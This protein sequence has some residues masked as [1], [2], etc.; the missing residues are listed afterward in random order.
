MSIICYAFSCPIADVVLR[1]LY[2]LVVDNFGRW[3]GSWLL[4]VENLLFA[5]NS[6]KNVWF[7]V[8]SLLDH[9]S[10]VLKYSLNLD[11]VDV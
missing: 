11:D 1:E 8:L 6:W 7:Q 3:A 9:V 2:S 4:V 10:L 5:I